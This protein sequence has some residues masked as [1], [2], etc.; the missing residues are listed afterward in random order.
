MKIKIYFHEMHIFGKNFKEIKKKCKRKLKN[1]FYKRKFLE[2][3]PI[4]KNVQTNFR[5]NLK[6]KL[7]K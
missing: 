4:E 5:Q 7:K 1:I 6:E 2:N 3:F